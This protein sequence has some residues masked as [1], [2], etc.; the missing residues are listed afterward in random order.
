M[1]DEKAHAITLLVLA[2][3]MLADSRAARSRD[4]ARAVGGPALES[5]RPLSGLN[6][7]IVRNGFLSAYGAREGRD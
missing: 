7:E 5:G 3:R 4:L 2:A 1:S 6:P